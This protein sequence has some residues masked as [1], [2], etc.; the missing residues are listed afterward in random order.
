MKFCRSNSS[1]TLFI[2]CSNCEM[3]VDRLTDTFAAY[4]Y[5]QL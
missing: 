2:T 3:I 5:K 4:N 1:L